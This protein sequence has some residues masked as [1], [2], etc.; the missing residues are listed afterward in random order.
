MNLMV[1][2]IVAGLTAIS[3]SAAAQQR[4]PCRD[5]PR[6]DEVIADLHRPVFFDQ[7]EGGVYDQLR[8]SLGIQ[9]LASTEPVTI[10]NDTVVCEA[11]LPVIE[12]ALRSSY[13]AETTTDGFLFD[14]VQY[15]PYMTVTAF[16]DP[17]T[18][19]GAG[20]ALEFTPYFIF[21]AATKAYIGKVGV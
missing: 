11:W 1:F 9:K 8:T 4:S 18:T 17:A 16:V 7:D 13:G 21:D 14:L 5:V 12:A 15:G 20:D 19:P 10:V 6:T 3:A 2:L